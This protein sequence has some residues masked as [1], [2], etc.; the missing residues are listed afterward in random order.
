MSE[1]KSVDCLSYYA[2]IIGLIYVAIGLLNGFNLVY[3]LMTSESLPRGMASAHS[4]FLCMSILIL[5]VGLGMRNWARDIE[6]KRITS[7]RRDVRYA[8]TS[9]FLLA[10]GAI[11]PSFSSFVQ[12]PPLTLI[13]YILYF[14]G[15]LMVSVGWILGGR[16]TK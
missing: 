8:Q 1:A 6:D 11:L 3:I 9:V 14:I 5:V 13:G 7:S 12:L 10:L 2:I 15:F 16:R 4:H